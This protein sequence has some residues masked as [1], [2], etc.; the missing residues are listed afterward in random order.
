MTVT[1]TATDYD[2]PP[3]A[4]TYSLVTFPTGATINTNTGVVTWTP[5]E[6]QGRARPPSGSGRWTTAPPMSSTNLFVITVTETNNNAPI[7]PA[8]TN[9]TVIETIL[10]T[11]NNGATDADLAGQYADLFVSGCSDRRGDFHGGRDHRTP[12]DSF[13][14]TTNTF[15]TR[16]VDNGRRRWSATN[17]FL[18]IVLDTNN[19]PVLPAQTNRTIAELTSLTVTNT[20]TD[21][22]IPTNSFTY[23]F[24]VRP[25]QPPFR[26]TA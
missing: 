10:M 14:G 25:P 15:T 19:A 22:D 20:A 17:T 9:R 23:S 11:V 26:P 8:Q 12:N 5:T 18:V 3:N 21:T 7:L 24:L 16:V 4:V 1:N 13:G 2:V 6:A